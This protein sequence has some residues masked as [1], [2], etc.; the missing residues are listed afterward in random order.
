MIKHL[1]TFLIVVLF[2]FI[3]YHLLSQSSKE[4]EISFAT[5]KK[6]IATHL[7]YLQD[8]NFKPEIAAKAFNFGK[9][10]N[11][12][13]KEIAEMLIQI[14]NG[15]LLIVKIDEIPNDANYLD[16]TLDKHRYAPFPK[17]LPSVYLNKIGN[18]WLYSKATIDAI[19][20]LYKETFPFNI[21]DISSMVPEWSKGEFLGLHV[22]QYIGLLTL[23]LISYIIYLLL[24]WLF[25]YF[26]VRIFKR[27]ARKDIYIKYVQPVAR[28][29]SILVVVWLFKVS[30][31]ILA[32]PISVAN[33]I[34]QAMY[35][36]QPILLAV[37]AYK[38]TNLITDILER[39][40]T[41]TKST[42]DDHLVPL[43]N[44]TLKVIVVGL[45]SI[46]VI[47]N[48]G[49]NI[50]PLLA[51]ASIGGLAI[52]FAAKETLSNLFGSVT[53][54][55]DQ[56]FEIGDWIE[57]GDMGGTVEE[58]GMRSTRIRTFYDSQ[59]TIPNGKLADS[60]ID[61]MGRRTYRR[62]NT[63][64]TITYD[65]PPDLIETFIEGLKKIVEDHPVTRK[66]YYQIH[67]N[68][69]GKASINIIF[70]IFFN[71]PDWGAELKARG[72]ILDDIIR[73]ASTLGV[74]FAFPSQTIHIEDFPEKKS[75]T[76]VY[77]ASRED[78]MN[79]LQEF[80]EKRSRLPRRTDGNNSREV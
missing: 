13:K 20:K 73:L 54:F 41:K 60:A 59:I 36:I 78:F 48:L 66:D 74:R 12:D 24:A 63:Q 33:F 5:P 9:M 71:V 57:W 44:K 72:E 51:G 32:L 14:Y 55:T 58:V 61:N 40:A 50:T 23:V 27:Y 77:D 6:T 19:P 76:P 62:F 68:E 22:W 64:I 8:D 31:H 70:Y 69:L 26:I 17:E 11:D 25:G 16:S 4:P 10:S 80:N 29:F 37:I 79:R 35:V 52:A 30:V 3:T 43:V 2:V 28:P 21:V 67:L 49:Y 34:A 42:I 7:S 39:M 53:I 15:R 47:N 38:L 56:P 18:K 65:T 46:Y 75:L 45:G 1:Y